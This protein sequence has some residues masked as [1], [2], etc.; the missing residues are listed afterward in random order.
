MN[1]PTLIIT[2]L[3]MV[4][5][6]IFT[7]H[8]G[9]LQKPFHGQDSMAYSN[10][11]GFSSFDS[12]HDSWSGGNCAN[13]H[14]GSGGYGSGWWFGERSYSML[15]RPHPRILWTSISDNIQYAE[16]KV[17]SKQCLV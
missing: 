1:T 2:L 15:T 17:H 10:A 11:R 14:S 16:M 7:L 3:L 12:D 9:Q 13:V 6:A 5:K 4:Q 8:I